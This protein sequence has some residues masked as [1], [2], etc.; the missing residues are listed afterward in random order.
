MEEPN[1][2]TTTKTEQTGLF[3]KK[4]VKRASF[5]LLKFSKASPKLCFNVFNPF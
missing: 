4:D 2:K 1:N 3:A 5:K